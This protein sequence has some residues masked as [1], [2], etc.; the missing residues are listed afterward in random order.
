MV[1]LQSSLI[2]LLCAYLWLISSTPMVSITIN[3]LLTPKHPS[4]ACLLPSGPIYTTVCWTFSL[5][6]PPNTSIS[7]YSNWTHY[8]PLQA[9]SNPVL[10]FLIDKYNYSYYNELLSSL[11]LS[12]ILKF[13]FCFMYGA[14]WFAMLYYFQ[15]YSKGIQLYVY[16]FC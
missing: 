12:L 2:R 10:L 9:S 7:I 6:Y 1:I 8:L 5:P 3:I 4:S 13:N 15:V 11:F 14:S 16:S